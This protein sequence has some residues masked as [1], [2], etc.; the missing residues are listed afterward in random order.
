[1]YSF[2]PISFD[3]QICRKHQDEE[4]KEADDNDFDSVY[5][6]STVVDDLSESEPEPNEVPSSLLPVMRNTHYTSQTLQQQHSI[7]APA[8]SSNNSVE[9][10]ISNKY[11]LRW[12]LKFKE[13]CAYKRVHGHTDVPYKQGKL[14]SWVKTQRNNYYLL[15]TRGQ[16]SEQDKDKKKI[17]TEEKIASL[18]AI[19]FRWCIFAKWEERFQELIRFKEK[20]NHVDVPQTYPGLGKW[21]MNQRRNYKLFMENKKSP[22]TLEKIRMFEAVGF[23]WS[24]N[25][26]S[27]SQ[28]VPWGQRYQELIKFKEKFSHVNVPRDGE[29]KCLRNW[30][31]TQRRQNTLLQQNKHS[32]LT[33]ERKVLLDFIGFPW[34]I[35]E[36]SSRQNITFTF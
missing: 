18:D 2:T 29:Y 21:V 25:Q 32:H 9:S 3:L 23:K 10:S 15:S 5:D 20:Y 24:I 4:K 19:G 27:I 12:C 31:D 8:F 33:P 17:L 11:D 28:R 13:L 22:L 26:M 34:S 16:S 6:A 30:V 1:M 7:Q 36:R 35:R 14:G